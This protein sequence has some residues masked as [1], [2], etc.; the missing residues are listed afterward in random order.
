MHVLRADRPQNYD[1]MES[2]KPEDIIQE[3]ESIPKF[4][5]EYFTQENMTNLWI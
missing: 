5:L 3:N 2:L 1:C 4:F